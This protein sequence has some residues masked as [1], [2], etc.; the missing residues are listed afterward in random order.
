MLILAP[1]FSPSQ[2]GWVGLVCNCGQPE[3]EDAGTGGAQSMDGA[4]H[5]RGT[6]SP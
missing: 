1:G 2:Q 6:I 5:I 3:E 4:A